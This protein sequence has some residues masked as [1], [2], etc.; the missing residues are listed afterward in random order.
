MSALQV[1]APHIN[2]N[3]NTRS[4]MLNNFRTQ[5]SYS[6]VIQ[7]DLHSKI[8]APL[9]EN[10]VLPLLIFINLF[11]NFDQEYLIE[12]LLEYFRIS[13]GNKPWASLSHFPDIETSIPILDETQAIFFKLV[14]KNKKFILLQALL[15]FHCLHDNAD[16]AEVLVKL[17]MQDKSKFTCKEHFFWI[18]YWYVS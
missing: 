9:S 8:F 5:S 2:Y 16:L 14:L 1:N 3:I 12:A 17:G 18:I 6:V 13:L 11:Q 15:Q 4:E 7:S 10:E